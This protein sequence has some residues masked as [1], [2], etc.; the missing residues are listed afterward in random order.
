MKKYGKQKRK[1]L[2]ITLRGWPCQSHKGEKKM[3]KLFSACLV[4][5]LAIVL[6]NCDSE[7]SNQQTIMSGPVKS[8]QQATMKDMKSL[9]HAIESYLTDHYKVPQAADMDE[10]EKIL[11]PVFTKVI[12]KKDAWGNDFHYFHG[13]EGGEEQQDYAIGSG[14]SDGVFEGFNFDRS[15]KYIYITAKGN[16][17]VFSNGAFTS[18]PK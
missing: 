7:K 16:D 12:V 9:S 13:E 17:I 15:R 1:M 10:L 11:V 3:K 4:L 5:V 6:I 18:K 8:K 2:T 14:G